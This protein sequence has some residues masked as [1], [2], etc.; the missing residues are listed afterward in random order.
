MAVTSISLDPEKCGRPDLSNL[1]CRP[2]GGERKF[3]VSCVRRP[4][5]S[6]ELL[7]SAAWLGRTLSHQEHVQ[8]DLSLLPP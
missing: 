5:T 7:S 1:D 3:Q 2:D 4:L 6:L 8:F